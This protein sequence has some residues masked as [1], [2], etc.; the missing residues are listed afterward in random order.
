M[1][2]QE[3]LAAFIANLATKQS[4][5]APSAEYLGTHLES[6]D[7]IITD[8]E[9]TALASKVRSASPVVFGNVLKAI[10]PIIRGFFP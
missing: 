7:S 1:N 5:A 4:A 6:P 10:V 8:A 9:A 2:P 3:I